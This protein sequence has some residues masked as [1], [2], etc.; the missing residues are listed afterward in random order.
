MSMS[1]AE[2][3]GCPQV[4]ELVARLNDAQVEA[5]VGRVVAE[6]QGYVIALRRSRGRMV[7]LRS[8]WRYW[9]CRVEAWFWARRRDR[10]AARIR[11]DIECGRVGDGRG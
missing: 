7:P 4:P 5:G 3:R 9:C 1:V 2:D 6:L 8:W 11:G 10:L